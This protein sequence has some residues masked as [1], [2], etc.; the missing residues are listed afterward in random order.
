LVIIAAALANA[1][2]MRRGV[3][4]IVNVLDLLPED[5]LAE[6]MDDAE[7]VLEALREA[8]LGNR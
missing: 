1:R 6:V 3:P 7:A 2:G 8:G 4:K 5:I